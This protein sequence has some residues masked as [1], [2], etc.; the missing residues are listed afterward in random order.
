MDR[1][2]WLTQQRWLA[3]GV[4][5]LRFR[6]S[7]GGELPEWE[8][9]A[10]ITITLPNG[11]ARDYSLCS[12]PADRTEWTVAVLRER[13]SRGGSSYVHEQLRVG[14]QLAVAG[15]RNNFPLRPADSYLLIAGGIG[16]TPIKAMAE[17]LAA[18]EVEWS[19]L[20]CGRSRAG[21]AYLSELHGIAGA[22]LRLHCDDEQGGPPDLATILAGCADGTQV[23]CCGPEALLA[24][25]ESQMVDP[26]LLH[27]ER[28]RAAAPVEATGDESAFDVVCAG[29]GLRV[30]VQP[31]VSIVDSLASAGVEVL[32]SCREGICGTCETKVLGGVPQHRDSILTDQERSAG[33]TMMLCVSRCQSAELELDLP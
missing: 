31:G 22:R 4:H 16:I 26:D 17:R 18:Q 28:F 14:E 1:L 7:D 21:M 2:V 33:E 19:M 30:T 24:A 5:E 9:G 8:P 29:S 12:D 15:P 6:A 23:Y 10:H 25:V 13:D 20:Y 27:I 32:T 11:Q 3:E